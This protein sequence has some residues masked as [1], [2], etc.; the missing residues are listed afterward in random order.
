MG[1]YQMGPILK[2]WWNSPFTPILGDIAPEEQSR[3][4]C[5]TPKTAMKQLQPLCNGTA[6]QNYGPSWASESFK[7]GV[8]AL[9]F[10][11]FFVGSLSAPPCTILGGWIY[12]GPP[13]RKFFHRRPFP[14]SVT[15]GGFSGG[16]G[17]RGCN[18]SPENSS[19]SASLWLALCARPDG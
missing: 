18:P 19:S 4:A 14:F 12:N 8:F 7:T 15:K 11:L 2:C 16:E 10:R 9:G 1:E 6:A 17:T 13:P 3:R 5:R